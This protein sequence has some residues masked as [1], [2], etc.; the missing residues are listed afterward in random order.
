[1]KPAAC[2][3]FDIMIRRQSTEGDYLAILLNSP[4]GECEQ[5]F[6]LR[7][8]EE[9][10]E[11]SIRRISDDDDYTA[12]RDIGRL[13]FER[14]FADELGQHW[15]ACRTVRPIR[16]RLRLHDAYLSAL[17]WELMVDS[18][19]DTFLFGSESVSL[20][21]HIPATGIPIHAPESSLFRIL[22]ITAS[23]SDDAPLDVDEEARQIATAI[24][25]R[26]PK[27]RF[28]IKMLEPPTL[29]RLQDEL[30][31]QQYGTYSVI[32]FAGHGM[33][34]GTTRGTWLD[35]ENDG[36]ARKQVS[37]L[38]FAT[39]VQDHGIRLA[40]LNCCESGQHSIHSV[41][42]GLAAV[43]RRIG[44]PAVVAMQGAVDDEAAILFASE[45]YQNLA[46]GKSLDE[47]VSRGRKSL[48]RKFDNHWL[49]RP[50]LFLQMGK[51]P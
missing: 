24:A 6:S 35:F 40:F 37:A 22:L 16:I 30:S 5:N 21:R 12:A 9:R 23:P 4:A 7:G 39:M 19:S 42:Y 43:L 41:R 34:D 17:P 26:D 29:E 25:P 48:Y 32:H 11:E 44:V 28:E 8:T 27:R 31:E 51:I 18:S 10:I 46:L 15:L 33:Y 36:G 1:M 3:E 49:G 45:F 47:A 38:Q 20:V 14:L 50:S 2:P 13:C